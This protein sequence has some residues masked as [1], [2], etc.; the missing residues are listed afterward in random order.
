MNERR[1]VVTG[2]GVIS[3]V[4]KTVPE[5]WE[6]LVEG[7]CGLGPITRFDA[8]KCR[9]QIAGEINDFD[10]T[11]YNMTAKDAK[12]HDRFSQLAIAAS[13]EALKSA[14]LPVDLRES[15]C[16][17]PTRV[18]VN[19][20][21]GVGGLSSLCDQHEIM[22]SRGPDRVSPL[23]IPTMICDIASGNISILTGATGPNTCITT[24]CASGCHSIGEAMWTIKRDD[25]DIMICGGAEAPVLPIAVGG[26]SAMKAMSQRNDDPL[27]ASRPF[28]LNRD[29]FVMSE[30]AGVLILEELNH[31]LKR[32]A[33]IL[34]ELAGYGATGDAYHIT[35]PAPDGSGAG[36]AMTM[37]LRHAGLQ[38][39]AIDYI[40]AHGTSTHLNDKFETL[41]IKQCFGEHA[42]KVAVSSTKGVTGHGLGA[43]GSFES[44]ACIKAIETGIIPPTINYETPD[45]ECDLNITPNVAVNRNVDAALNMNLGFGGHNAALVFR[46]Y[47]G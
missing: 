21:S 37:A 44:I 3:C 12:R 2:Y 40:N 23:L 29:G 32:G 10:P 18:G 16:V 7:R 34:A 39:E 6:S 13:V 45:P 35:S 4:G 28:D 1:V 30:G 42:Y 41:A 5:F 24:A 11:L 26:F 20:S 19:V 43:A 17:D 15:T 25:A 38:P 8:S 33:T 36:R 47:K 31:A 46:K 14:G 27:H 22:L 9:T